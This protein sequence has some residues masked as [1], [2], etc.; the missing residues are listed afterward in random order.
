MK[1][2]LIRVFRFRSWFL[3]IKHG[4]CFFYIYG[5][6]IH[7]D[8]NKDNLVC[9]WFRCINFRCINCYGCNMV[10][11]IRKIRVWNCISEFYL[12]ILHSINVF[13]K[14]FYFRLCWSFNSF[15]RA[16]LLDIYCASV[17]TFNYVCKFVY[18]GS[19]LINC[20]GVNIY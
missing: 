1:L 4:A 8:N 5:F 17:Y 16:L 18:S 15:N 12:K 14:L 19:I 9:S 10:C 11:I 6:S 20:R 3:I 2:F 7:A 13:I